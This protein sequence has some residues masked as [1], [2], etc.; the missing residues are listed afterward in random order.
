MDLKLKV[1]LNDHAHCIQSTTLAFLTHAFLVS[2]LLRRRFTRP[3][4]IECIILGGDWKRGTGHR[5]TI[6]IVRAD[7]ARVDNAAP[8]SSGGQ[9]ENW[10]CG[11]ISQGWTTRNRT[12]RRHIADVDITEHDNAAPYQT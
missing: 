9:R 2:R 3:R 1:T 12:I 4:L 5:E 6:E 7:I 10:Q 8:Y 11:T